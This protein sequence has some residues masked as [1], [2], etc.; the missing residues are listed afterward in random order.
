LGGLD[1][2]ID[3]ICCCVVDVEVFEMA[4]DDDFERN[5]STFSF[6]IPTNVTGIDLGMN[7][8]CFLLVLEILH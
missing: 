4:V 6:Q 3:G 8:G 5:F 7:E 2:F 1:A